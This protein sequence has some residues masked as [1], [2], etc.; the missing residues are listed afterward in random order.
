MKRL[1]KIENKLFL[2]LQKR[3]NRKVLQVQ[4]ELL[5]F[6][7]P[8]NSNSCT[9]IEQWVELLEVRKEGQNFRQIPLTLAKTREE[10]L[11]WLSLQKTPII[12]KEYELI[13]QDFLDFF[14]G[15]DSYCYLNR[16]T[17]VIQ[18]RPR[19]I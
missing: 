5:N 10:C 7:N 13:G 2:Y 1:E 16:I 11:V 12:F 8:L 15:F 17:K 19:K 6:F 18:T 9:E 3:Q 4:K 14:K